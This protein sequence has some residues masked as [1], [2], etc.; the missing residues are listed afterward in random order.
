MTPEQF[1]LTPVEIQHPLWDKLVKHYTARLTMLR[2]EN[3]ADLSETQTANKRG[4]I[5]ECKAFLALGK[6]FVLPQ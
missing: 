6:P 4:R 2:L 5:A 3:D 1:E